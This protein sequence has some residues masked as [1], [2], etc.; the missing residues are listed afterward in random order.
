MLS[1]SND[2]VYTYTIH[3][4]VRVC[5]YLRM[6]SIYGHMYIYVYVYSPCVHIR[7]CIQSMCMYINTIY[8]CLYRSG[9]EIEAGYRL[10]VWDQLGYL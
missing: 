3:K 6:Y 9:A 10:E 2:F 4:Y 8:V 1:F 7:I 5:I